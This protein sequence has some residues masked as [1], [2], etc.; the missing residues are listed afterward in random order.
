MA[1]FLVSSE[2][3]GQLDGARQN[4]LGKNGGEKFL[5]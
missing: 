1:K 5:S 2:T 4:I 3:L